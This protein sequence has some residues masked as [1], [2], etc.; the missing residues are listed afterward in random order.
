MSPRIFKYWN[1]QALIDWLEQEHAKGIDYRNLEAALRLNYGALDWWRTGMAESLGPSELQAL[2]DYRGWS[3]AQVQQ[4]L[5][6]KP[7]SEQ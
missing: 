5:G 7:T 1:K 6:I 3:V 4:W 2:A